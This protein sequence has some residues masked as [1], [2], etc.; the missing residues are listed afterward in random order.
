MTAITGPSTKELYGYCKSLNNVCRG[1]G[2]Q[3]VYNTPSSF[4]VSLNRHIIYRLRMHH[5]V[6]WN[7]LRIQLTNKVGF[8]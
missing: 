1:K 8:K 2:A 6:L 5:R 3:F 7:A 4:N